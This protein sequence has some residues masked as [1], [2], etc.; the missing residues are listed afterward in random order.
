VPVPN[1]L[2]IPLN[3][4]LIVDDNVTF[5]FGT[6]FPPPVKVPVNPVKFKFLQVPAPGTVTVT[7]PEAASKNTLSSAVGREAP[8]GPPEVSDHLKFD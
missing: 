6:R 3:V 7:E 4:K 1:Q 2:R 8:A 5:P